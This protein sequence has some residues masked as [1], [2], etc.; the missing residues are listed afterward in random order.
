MLIEPGQGQNWV[1]TYEDANGIWPLSGTIE[2]E[3]YNYNIPNPD[4]IIW[5]QLTWMPQ[6][7]PNA[8]IDVRAN[9]VDPGLDPLDPAWEAGSVVA[10]RDELERGFRRLSMDHRVV[11]VLRFLLL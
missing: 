1:E 3:L 6:V 11:L 7:P 10:D 9:L 4:K 8:L 2:V 5:I